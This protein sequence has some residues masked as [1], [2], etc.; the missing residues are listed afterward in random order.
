MHLINLFGPPAVGKMSVGREIAARTPYRLFH[1][2]ATI[3]PLLEV[4]DWEM[5]SFGVLKSE[6]RRRVIEE[7]VASELPGLIF[8]FVW[9]LDLPEDTRAVETLIAPVAAAGG[10]IDFVELYAD[11]PTRLGREG[12]PERL[13]AKP[14]KRDTEWAR[15]N[16]VDW[17]ERHELSTGPDVPFPL[18]F[19]HTVVD[20]TRLSAAETA[21][22]I[23]TRLGLPTRP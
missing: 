1:N 22:E 12:T 17:N 23:I 8:T 20:N 19:P 9:A 10:R 21:E 14:S 15:A 16:V 4:F 11:L 18:D 7:A 2:H 6:F 13:A 3:E 5:P